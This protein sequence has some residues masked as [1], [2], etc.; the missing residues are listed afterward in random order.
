MTH[1]HFV[2]LLLS[3][4]SSGYGARMG[5]VVVE[6]N[7]YA[8]A[9]D[10]SIE[11]LPF[12]RSIP[13][14]A[15]NRHKIA[16]RAAYALEHAFFIDME[17]FSPH[18]PFLIGAFS[19]AKNR[20]V[21]RHFGKIT[22][23]LLRKKRIVLPLE[24]SSALAETAALWLSDP[25]SKVAVKVL[26]FD[27]LSLLAPYLPWVSDL[28]PDAIGLLSNNP[29]PGIIARLNRCPRETRF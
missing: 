17:R 19:K 15:T 11:G 23:T 10:L 27:L 6:N 4:I 1:D 24:Q 7:L 2:Q 29:T 14:T 20:S 26:S 16:F 5:R 28:L 3:D 8:T 9:I 21:H 25:K 13:S 22:S 18:I 12:P